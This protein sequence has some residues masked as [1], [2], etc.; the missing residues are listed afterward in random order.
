MNERQLYLMRHTIGL[1]YLR[2][3]DAH[4]I[5]AEPYRNYFAASLGSED[6]VEFMRMVHSGLAL[7]PVER[8]GHQYFSLTDMGL[9]IAKESAKALAKASKPSKSKARYQA[10]RHSES[11]EKFIDWL[12]NP[13]WD[14]Y[15]RR[16]GV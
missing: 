6:Y 7:G 14:D 11:D 10:Y 2:W 4:K 1:N 16:Y 5:D 9:G 12:K 13:F 15:R 8:F 3:Y